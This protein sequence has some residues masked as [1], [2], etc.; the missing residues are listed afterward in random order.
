MSRSVSELLTIIQRVEKAGA[1]LES[2]TE[3]S[4][5]QQAWGK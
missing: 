4:I 3:K 5:E 2:L 1:N